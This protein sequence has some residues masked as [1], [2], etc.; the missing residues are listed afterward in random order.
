MLDSGPLATPLIQ[1]LGGQA[2]G[3]RE[4]IRWPL[5]LSALADMGGGGVWMFYNMTGSQ[6]SGVKV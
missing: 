3:F 5:F 2:H 1:D 4:K 6:T